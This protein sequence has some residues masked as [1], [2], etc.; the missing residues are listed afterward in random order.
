MEGEFGRMT[1][2]ELLS[3]EEVEEVQVRRVPNLHRAMYITADRKG[4]NFATLQLPPNYWYV[5]FTNA[6]ESLSVQIKLK[7]NMVQSKT[8]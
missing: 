7:C 2:M 4:R 8:K 3:R 1:L 5:Q 6:F